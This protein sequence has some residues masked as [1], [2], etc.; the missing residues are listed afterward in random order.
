M[1]SGHSIF[2][3]EGHI[4]QVSTTLLTGCPRQGNKIGL[5]SNEKWFKVTFC[6]K[7]NVI[8]SHKKEW[9]TKVHNKGRIKSWLNEK[10]MFQW[11]QGCDIIHARR[12]YFLRIRY[13]RKVSAL[14]NF[15]QAFPAQQSKVI[16]SYWR[17]NCK[18]KRGEK[19]NVNTEIQECWRFVF[20][21]I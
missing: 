8:Y 7:T 19:W 21:Y 16:S 6:L 2:I 3:H 1:N 18:G 13:R 14:R 10:N 11:F 17:L 12:E 20:T 9:L 4:S 5:G 15:P